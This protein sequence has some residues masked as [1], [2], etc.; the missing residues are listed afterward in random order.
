MMLQS[1]LDHPA[2]GSV[3]TRIRLNASIVISGR[4]FVWAVHQLFPAAV[5]MAERNS[6]PL[7]AGLRLKIGWIE[8]HVPLRWLMAD[9]AAKHRHGIPLKTH[10]AGAQLRR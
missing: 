8:L 10:S 3:K 2:N 9:Q 7:A 1:G 6:T 4:R 5:G